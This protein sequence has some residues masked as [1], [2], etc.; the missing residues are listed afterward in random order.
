MVKISEGIR[1][2]VFTPTS[3]NTYSLINKFIKRRLGKGDKDE[4]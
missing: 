1:S 4:K 2:D 3:F